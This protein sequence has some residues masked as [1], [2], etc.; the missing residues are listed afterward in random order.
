M[1]G[2]R[3]N[4]DRGFRNSAYGCYQRPNFAHSQGQLGSLHPDF[5][6]SGRRDNLEA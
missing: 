3:T 1:G 4:T 6:P 2:H 5:L